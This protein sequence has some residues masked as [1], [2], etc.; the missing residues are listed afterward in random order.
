MSTRGAPADARLERRVE[1]DRL[2]AGE[3]FDRNSALRVCE[4]LTHL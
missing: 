1:L 2:R 3:Q 4:Y